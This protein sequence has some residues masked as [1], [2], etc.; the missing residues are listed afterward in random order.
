[1]C[2]LPMTNRMRDKVIMSEEVKV[3]TITKSETTRAQLSNRRYYNT[4]ETRGRQDRVNLSCVSTSVA[5]KESPPF[6]TF[7][8]HIAE[9]NEF[10][11]VLAFLSFWKQQGKLSI[12]HRFLLWL[13]FNSCGRAF[14]LQ[15]TTLCFFMFMFFRA[16]LM[17]SLTHI[18]STVHP[19]ISL[20]RRLTYSAVV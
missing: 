14:W 15:L 7:T 1:M 6:L 9:S 17:L 3:N 18:R 5:L 19:V 12:Y 10:S 11:E 2:V 20:N 13:K 4:W 16:G 8:L